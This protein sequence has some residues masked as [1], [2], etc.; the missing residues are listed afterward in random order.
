[1]KKPTHKTRYRH[2]R[3]H[4]L[5][6]RRCDVIISERMNDTTHRMLFEDMLYGS[7]WKCN[8]F[9]RAVAII[10]FKYHITSVLIVIIGISFLHGLT[11]VPRWSVLDIC[12]YLIWLTLKFNLTAHF[13]L[14]A[15][16]LVASSRMDSSPSL[17]HMLCIVIASR[18]HWSPNDKSDHVE[19]RVTFHK[20]LWLVCSNINVVGND[21]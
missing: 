10:Q 21:Y 16:L 11:E 12:R 17:A 13:S 9:L 8:E 15:C 18:P 5:I 1:M 2:P 6:W 19:P 4:E 14:S 20:W 7:K 3:Y